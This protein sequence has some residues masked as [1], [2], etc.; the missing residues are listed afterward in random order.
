MLTV[1]RHD[2]IKDEL[3]QTGKVSSSDLALRLGVSDDTIRRDLRMLAKDGF[4]RRVYG[5]AVAPYAGPIAT[6]LEQGTE[7]KT[8]LA[9]AAAALVEPGQ[10][11]F[12]DAG[13]TNAAIA[14]H[15][16]EGIGLTVVTNALAHATLLGPRLGIKLE[17][18]GGA[19]DRESG[20]FF[21]DAAHSTISGIA[22]D[23]FFLGT[24]GLNEEI[25]ATAYQ[26]RDARIKRAMASASRRIVVAATEEKL[27]T[28]ATYRV[29]D[30][31]QIDTI[32]VP[33]RADPKRWAPFREAGAEIVLAG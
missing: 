26:G 30:L 20:A 25:G 7:E 1:Q 19:L 3:S 27:G 29:A 23:L 13:S 21:G 9:K 15:L 10:T 6:R 31:D 32:V 12:L 5:G 33:R 14:K 22:A 2:I 17:V 16:P 4:C 8:L 28:R 24:C 11:I 18:I